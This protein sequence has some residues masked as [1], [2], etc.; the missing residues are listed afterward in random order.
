MTKKKWTITD[1]RNLYHIA[2]WGRPFFDINAE[3]NV[4]VTP[5]PKKNG[6]LDLNFLIKDLCRRGI[7]PPLLIRFNDILHARLEYIGEAFGN[8]IEVYNYPNGYQSVLPIKVNQQRHVVQELL[9]KDL[10]YK[11]GLEAGSKPEL[12]AAISMLDEQNPLIIC[13]GYK[14]N[15]YIQTALDAQKLGLKPFLVIDRF[16]EL[17]QIIELGRKN[18][19]IPFIGVRAKLTTRGSGRWEQSSGDR[20]KFGL[21]ASELVQLV[22]VLKEEQLLEGL[23]L[24]HFHIGSQITAIRSVKKAVREAG[25]LYCQLRELGA[26]NLSCVDVGGGLAVDYDGSMSN[27]P[28]S[29]NYTVQEYAND[30]VSSMAAICDM[31]EVPPPTIFSE[32]GR[33]LAAHHSVLVFNILGVHTF[34][35]CSDANVKKPSPNSHHILFDFWEAYSTIHIEN[36]QEIYNDVLALKEEA[37]TLFSHGVIDLVTRSRSEDLFWATVNKIHRMIPELEYIPDDFGGMDSLLSDTYYGNFS[38]FQSLPDSWAVDHLFPTLPIHRLNQEP[39]RLGII[40]DLTCDS[41]GKID[42]FI[43]V[44]GERKTLQLHPFT[45]APYYIGVF[46]VGAY[47]ETLGDL[48]NLFGDTNAVHVSVDSKGNY[49]LE[50]VVIGDSVGEVLSYVEYDQSELLRCFRL[51]AEKAVR[52]GALSLEECAEILKRYQEGLQGYTYLED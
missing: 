41:D 17:F 37:S 28:S 16:A 20:S 48:H 19:I 23:Q 11:L 13:N 50:H 51:N 47:Q 25:Y 1:S 12:L 9:R 32:S 10:P 8:S 3:G 38:V 18:N 26:T 52:S 30:V 45:E 43:N 42:K 33:A 27:V 36:L 39:T 34:P 2:R 6:T 49:S 15:E 14:D 40:A 21:S 7:H 29:K 4:S 5:N 22:E 31:N 35:D 46:L 24:L 44:H